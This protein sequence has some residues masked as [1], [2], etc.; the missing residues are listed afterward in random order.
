LKTPAD[1]VS[2]LLERP[3]LILHGGADKVVDI[4]PQ[5]E[6]YEKLRLVYKKNEGLKMVTYSN[7]GHFMSVN[8]VEE[9]SKWFHK[10]L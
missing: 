2:S 3:L 1:K 8:M 6:F 10:Y 4:T 5:K 7:L 9:M